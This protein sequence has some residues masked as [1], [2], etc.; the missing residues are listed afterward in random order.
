MDSQMMGDAQESFRVIIGWFMVH[1]QDFLL[2]EFPDWCN[3]WEL[4]MLAVDLSQC[5]RR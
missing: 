1:Y 3:C 2:R 5:Y 4:G